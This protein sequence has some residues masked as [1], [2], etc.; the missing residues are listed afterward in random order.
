MRP[1]EPGKIRLLVPEDEPMLPHTLNVSEGPF[2]LRAINSNQGYMETVP[3]SSPQLELVSEG[4][5]GQR[6]SA[7]EAR[8]SPASWYSMPCKGM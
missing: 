3:L 5:A 8:A 6:G 7:P 4:S 2:I 1:S